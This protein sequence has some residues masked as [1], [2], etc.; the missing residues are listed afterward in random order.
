MDFTSVFT[1][2]ADT[3]EDWF[4]DSKDFLK[5]GAE[6]YKTMTAGAKSSSMQ[7]SDRAVNAPDSNYSAGKSSSPASVDYGEYESLWKNRLSAM[8]E[9]DRNTG[10]TGARPVEVKA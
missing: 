5:L 4:S 2:A 3:I 9:I 1:D 6:A 10:V 7:I 8:L